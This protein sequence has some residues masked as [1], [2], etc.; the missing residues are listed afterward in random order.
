MMTSLQPVL[1]GCWLSPVSH[2]FPV[3]RELG[4]VVGVGGLGDMKRPQPGVAGWGL[5]F[6]VSACALIVR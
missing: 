1:G 4:G 2:L 3:P 5:V 6:M